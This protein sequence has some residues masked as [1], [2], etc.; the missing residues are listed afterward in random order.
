MSIERDARAT[1]PTL[2]F[3]AGS[4]TKPDAIKIK[5]DALEVCVI[6][7]S[8]LPWGVSVDGEPTADGVGPADLMVELTRRGDEGALR[9]R[10][11]LEQAVVLAWLDH[12]GVG[13]MR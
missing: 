3:L 9:V 7:V 5:V 1:R 6:L 2:E 10:D 11:G 8:G 4:D 12:V 13:D